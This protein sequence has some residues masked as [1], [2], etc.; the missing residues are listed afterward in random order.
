VFAERTQSW[1]QF[2][3]GAIK[4]DG[5]PDAENLFEAMIAIAEE[6]K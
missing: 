1:L 6:A 5:Q 2:A 4:Y 3:E